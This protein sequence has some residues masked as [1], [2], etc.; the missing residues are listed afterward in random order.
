LTAAAK[1]AAG[2]LF[3][4]NSSFSQ[5]RA[6][7]LLSPKPRAP[8]AMQSWTIAGVHPDSESATRS[9]ATVAQLVGVDADAAHTVRRNGSTCLLLVA[10]REIEMIGRLIVRLH[11]HDAQHYCCCDGWR[12]G[13]PGRN[14]EDASGAG[15]LPV[16]ERTCSSGLARVPQSSWGR[17]VGRADQLPRGAG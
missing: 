9:I 16:G 12:R 10:I 2:D 4:R 15:T 13:S 8:A 14:G 11:L 5:L 6:I 1:A 17:A 3:F 7:L